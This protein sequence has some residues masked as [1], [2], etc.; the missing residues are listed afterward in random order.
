MAFYKVLSRNKLFPV[1]P[2][3][4][5]TNIGQQVWKSAAEDSFPKCCTYKTFPY[6]NGDLLDLLIYVPG[7]TALTFLFGKVL[8]LGNLALF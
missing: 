5:F 1:S 3:D 4:Y 8:L 7:L 6:K 2:L